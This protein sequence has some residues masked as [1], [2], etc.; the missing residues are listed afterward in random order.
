MGAK[1]VSHTHRSTMYGLK[2]LDS[3]VFLESWKVLAERR[4]R[5]QIQK[6]T[7]NNKS[8]SY[9]GW[10]NDL[11]GH[12]YLVQNCEMFF[13]AQHYDA[14]HSNFD[15]LYVATLKLCV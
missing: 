5:R 6:R 13:K 2:K 7:K 8:P 1:N 3:G 4:R 15:V 9:P 11:K 14:R 12:N 10:L